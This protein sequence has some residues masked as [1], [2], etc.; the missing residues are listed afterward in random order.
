[1]NALGH[2]LRRSRRLH[3][4]AIVVVGAAVVFAVVQLG[5]E[6]HVATSKTGVPVSVLKQLGPV[7]PSAGLVHTSK[8]GV[9]VSIRN[10]GFEMSTSDGAVG[11]VSA[12][13]AAGG[14]WTKH[15]KGATRSTPF[16]NE[17][18]AVTSSG[19]EQYLTVRKQ[20]GRRTW[21]WQLNTKSD[22]RGTPT[23]WVGFF[24]GQKMVPIGIAPVKILDATGKDVTPK[25]LHWTTTRTGGKWWLE[26]TLNDKALP[27]PY[28]ID[29]QEIFFRLLG[30]TATSTAGTTLT[31][32]IPP[33]ARANDL[34]LLH[35][36]SFST[37][38]PTT[39]VAGW[40]LVTNTN[41]AN[42]TMSQTVYWKKSTGADGGTTV[43]VTIA[44]NAAS[45]GI[46][47]DYRG[48]NTSAAPI[49]QTT[50]TTAGLTS[51]TV[52]CPALTTN[53][54]NEHLI[55][56]GAKATPGAGVWP[57]GP[58]NSAATIA[59]YSK[60]SS[61]IA[62]TS[63]TIAD[64]DAD[65]TTSGTAVGALTLTGVSS[66][67]QR[68]TGNTF[69][70]LPDTTAPANGSLLIGSPTNAYQ[71]SAGSNIFFNGNASGSFT[72]SDPITDAQ[73]SVDSVN[74]PAVATAGWTHALDLNT[75]SPNFT[76]TYTWTYSG[77]SIA[78]PTAA[79]RLLT[80][81]N[82]AG[83]TGT[84][85]VPMVQDISVPTGGALT[86]N[87]TAASGGAGTSSYLT[88]GTTVA[89]NTRT[90]YSADTGS[91]LATS[92]LTMATASLSGGVCGSYGL[93]AT[94]VGSPSQS[95]TD[96][97]CYL[98]TLTG[99]DHVGNAVSLSTTVEVGRDGADTDTAHRHPGQNP[100][101]QYF[102]SG[103]STYYY[104]PAVNGDF[105]VSDAPAD[106]GSGVGSNAFPGIGWD[107]IKASNPILY[108][109]LGDTSGTIATDS[110][111]AANNPGTYTGGYTQNQTGALTGDTDKAV[112]LNGTTGYVQNAAP[113]SL[114]VGA[115]A[116]SVEVWFKTTSATQQN[117]FSYGSLGRTATSSR[118]SS[119]PLRPS[120]PGAGGRLTRPSTAPS[121]FNDGA[122]H[123]VVETYDGTNITVYLDGVSLGSQ[124][125]VLNTSL[126][127][128]NTG[129]GS[130]FTAGFAT[131]S[132]DTNSGWPFNGTLDEVAVFPTVLSAG[133]ISAQYAARSAAIGITAGPVTKTASAWTSLTHFFTSA[134]SAA[135]APSAE[136]ITVFDSAGNSAQTTLNFAKD[137]TLPTG[138]AISVPAFSSTLGSIVI[139][140]TN[141]TDAGSGIAAVNGNVITRSNAQAPSGAGVCPAAG[142][143]GATVVTSPDTVPTDGQCYVY[144]LT[145]TDNVNNI[146]S[147]ASSPILVDT[148]PPSTPTVTFSG[149][150]AGNTYDNGAGTLFFRPSAG[151]TFTVNAA[152][153]D[154]QSGIKAGN[155]GYTFSNLNSNGGANFVPTQTNGALSVTF[156]ATTTGPTVAQSVNST[157]N[158]NTNSATAP[159]TITQDSTAPTA[160]VTAPTAGSYNAAGWPGSLSGTSADA[161]SG[162]SAVKLSIQDTTVG[163]NSCWNGATFTAACPN[164]VASV[165]TTSWS[166][167][168]ASGVLT[169]G[170]SYTATVQ[171]IDRVNNTN[172]SATTATWTYDTSPPTAAVT[173]PATGTHYNSG[174]WGSGTLS[175]TAADATSSVASV[176]I[177]IQKDGGASACWDGTDAAGH[178]TSACPNYVNVA[179]TTAWTKTL[180]AGSLVDGSS[181]VMTVKTT[182]NA[183]NANTNNTAATS[184]FVYDN[185]PPTATVTFPA[186]GTHY[187]SAGWGLGTL[188]GTAADATSTVQT[189]KLSIQ[190]TTV[191]GSS[192]WDGTDTAGHF[193]SACPNYV[194]VT[195]TTAWTKTLSA[196]SLVDGHA[197][198]ATVQTTDNATNANT[199]NNAATSNFVY[200]NTA[201]TAA[202]TFPASGT[203]YNSTGWGSGTL[204]GTAAD[205]ASTVASV[206]ISIQKDGGA[207][208]CWDG[209]DAAG[210]FTSACPNYVNVAGTTA[211][212]KTLSAGSLVNGS[213]YVLTVK[214]TDN[215]TNAN[216]NNTAT[217]SSF[218]YDTSAPT[219]TATLT[220]NGDYNAAGWPGAL[221]G[222]VT[223]AGTGSTVKVSI[224]DTTSAAPA[225]GTAKRSRP[226]HRSCPNYITATGTTA[227]TLATLGNAALAD[228]DAYTATIQTIDNATNANTNNTAAT[229]SFTYDNTPPTATV[230]F[231]ANG[232]YNSA[233][234]SPTLS[235]TVSDATSTVQRSTSR[236]R[237][238]R[239]AGSCW[240]GDGGHFTTAC[241]NY[242]TATGT[243]AWTLATLVNG[244][245]VDGHAYTATIQATDATN[246]NTNG[247][248]RNQRFTFDT[249]APTAAVTFPANGTHYNSAGWVSTLTGTV[250]DAGTRCRRSRSRSRTPPSA[251]GNCWD[252]T[253]GVGHF[254]A[255]C[256]NDIPATGTTAWTLATLGNGAL[257]DG[258]TYTARSRPSTTPPTTTPTATSP[259][260][261]SSTTRAPRRQQ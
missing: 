37:T 225:A 228:G 86:V 54:A 40:T 229:G 163:G 15:T 118:S 110:S 188:A 140:T 235:G 260:A 177:S 44:N 165:G 18:V 261:A 71:A 41:T 16:G 173:F 161:A 200:D 170:H 114:P 103:T 109:R 90:D 203:H 147:I 227:W 248:R 2:L 102:D 196:G 36:G 253:N 112:L 221:S 93:P 239:Q 6:R 70:L 238:R 224:Q 198:T 168:L 201:P 39:A 20:Q 141:Y 240:N 120:S 131:P 202:V 251:A 77:A 92:T 189:V 216:T 32:T 219:A 69:G 81:T 45:V 237:T 129:A 63:I 190:D 94:I 38:V 180:S 113:Y 181:Y 105:T 142:Y 13:A 12:A 28:T 75:T 84:Q 178:F 158:A 100:N 197:Y 164:Y 233:G 144:T 171:T 51:T 136:K 185:T 1:M 231:P 115:S 116:R 179:G 58:V 26:L 199:N 62:S 172:N 244:A 22:V 252:G 66:T 83:V 245:L 47:D 139:T 167:A 79:E 7:Q 155:A 88:S 145:G 137:M 222:T 5:G 82:G 25:G 143:V 258:D 117:L 211:W 29:P 159:F 57:A 150:S 97:N 125:A 10:G 87:G 134:A 133:T 250:T 3:F 160:S 96:G 220:T 65:V 127:A 46:I 176:Q 111:S 193:T 138:G 230:T 17:T 24:N 128:C 213:N 104:N 89:I 210:H 182:D 243:T 98:F 148:T 101:Y 242:I 72:V 205:A 126:A 9:K 42:T 23:G 27:V 8:K 174:G 208:A 149:L 146:A 232:D 184:T 95:V 247:D 31:V 53:I 107:Q 11:I 130:C 214:T 76:S 152:S 226:L 162:V 78:A 106:G 175:G 186:S 91:G 183:T 194:N 254:T 122:W 14:A 187:N 4:A 60:R 169:N 55:C 249:S 246:N 156:G 215:A 207:S 257:V 217:T 73:S 61:G 256:P 195:G 123:Q 33:T 68:G 119:R 108:W 157:N 74:Y 80:Q 204:S 259:S 121:A 49:Q 223:D 206:Q 34:L 99:T 30:G 255:A 50:T 151:G 19:A 85:T 59:S 166:F 192:C 124:A 209:T 43:A 35:A 218:T 48:V 64:W 236:S 52:I 67:A 154:A 191:G 132:T 56:M 153:T 212:S 241:P 135:S 21:R 234:W